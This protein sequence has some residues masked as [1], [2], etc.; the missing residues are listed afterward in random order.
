[1]R[2]GPLLIAAAVR[3]VAYELPGAF[4]RATWLGAIAF[5]FVSWIVEFRL[6]ATP[7]LST[8]LVLFLSSDRAISGA[9]N[10]DLSHGPRQPPVWFAESVKTKGRSYS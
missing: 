6:A 5:A 10:A 8:N 9:W 2:N 4:S 3:S 7:T 1:M